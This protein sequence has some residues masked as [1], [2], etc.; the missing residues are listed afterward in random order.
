MG[1]LDNNKAVPIARPD[2]IGPSGTNKQD[3]TLHQKAEEEAAKESK[4]PPATTSAPAPKIL[5]SQL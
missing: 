4:L 3:R 2:G 1:R 5:R